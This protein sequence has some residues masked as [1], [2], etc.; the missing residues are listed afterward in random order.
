MP[1]PVPLLRARF[2]RQ[3]KHCKIMLERYDKGQGCSEQNTCTTECTEVSVITLIDELNDC[4]FALLLSNHTYIHMTHCSPNLVA[5]STWKTTKNRK[6][7]N[8]SQT[9]S[10]KKRQTWCPGG[11]PFTMRNA[12][13]WQWGETAYSISH[14]ADDCQND[15]GTVK[16]FLQRKWTLLILRRPSFQ[17]GIIS[18]K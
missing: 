17:R 8:I 9:K 13:L 2:C 4:F 6:N 10:H 1:T 16:Q 15:S 14:C 12:S 18:V 11:L 5:Q 7:R 3:I